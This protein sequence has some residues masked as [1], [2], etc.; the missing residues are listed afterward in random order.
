MAESSETSGTLHHVS[1]GE[2]TPLVLIPGLG[3]THSMYAQQ[4]ESFSDRH[5]VVALDLRGT[6][7]SPELQGP[8]DTVLAR[9][10]ADVVA[11]L[12]ELGLD[13][14]HVA[15]ISYGGVLVQQLA[16]DH[17]GRW[18]SLTICDSFG[19]ITPHTLGDRLSLSAAK[20]TQILAWPP[21]V[22]QLL[23]P[24][25]RAQYRRWPDALPALEAA[26]TSPR[27]REMALQREAI[28]DVHLLAD[29]ATVDVPTLCLV[30]D[31]S[32]ILMRRMGEVARAIPGA[33]LQLIPDA[34]DPSNLCNRPVFESMLRA[35]LDDVDAR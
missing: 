10:A 11:L 8:A 23:V 24:A 20:Q 28:N 25:I 26:T 21:R 13:Q 18:L 1:R 4:L 19:D 5:R 7:A 29:L 12:D 3:A 22:R 16:I 17:P 14:V 30:G 9:Q 15:G 6:G 2:G 32:K 31:T 34:F 27:G 33:R 35:F